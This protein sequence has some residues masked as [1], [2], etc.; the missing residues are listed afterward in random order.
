MRTCEEVME[1]IQRD[2]DHDLQDGET[3]ALNAHME[4]CPDCQ[5]MY[6]RLKAMS[7]DLE[8]LP[9]V[10][11]PAGIV[12]TMLPDLD[13]RVAKEKERQQRADSKKTPPFSFRKWTAV[14][15]A[16][17]VI[18][19]GWT[20]ANQMG[21]ESYDSASEGASQNMTEEQASG[22]AES[23]GDAAADG[24]AMPKA[25][26]LETNDDSSGQQRE[27]GASAPE[28]EQEEM[29]MMEANDVAKSDVFRSP[30]G[31]YVA[32]VDQNRLIVQNQEGEAVFESSSWES[33]RDVEVRW[34]SDGQL[35][36]TVMGS[37]HEETWLVDVASGEQRKKE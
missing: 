32:K 34:D 24:E 3:E 11:P 1:L 16:L 20:V 27:E 37:N 19:V 36:Y 10:D 23:S 9:K 14:A 6:D 12:D 22:S 25:T 29:M 18:V 17:L 30:D 5:Q 26:E 15:A 21:S 8:A 35:S 33:D 28:N 2:L 13:Q 4:Q 31:D 7:D